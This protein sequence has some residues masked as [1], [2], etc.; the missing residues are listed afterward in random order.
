MEGGA[1]VVVG[2]STLGGGEGGGGVE[3]T[4]WREDVQG[5]VEM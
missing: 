5:M 2:E 4:A 1:E 3:R